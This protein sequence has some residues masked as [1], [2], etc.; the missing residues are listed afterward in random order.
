MVQITITK[1]TH[2]GFDVNQGD[3]TADG[4]TY[5]EVLGVISV[6][7]ITELGDRVPCAH[8]MK[9]E[10]EDRKWRESLQENKEVK[11]E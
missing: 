5:E 8:W 4:L 6:L 10:E 3:R 7:L 11:Y 2:R 1:S 9:T